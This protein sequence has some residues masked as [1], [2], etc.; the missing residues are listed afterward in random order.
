MPLLRSWP[1]DPCRWVPVRARV[2]VPL[3]LLIVAAGAAL[4]LF[5]A[6]SAGVQPTPEPSDTPPPS[7]GETPAPGEPA[8][9]P[10]TGEEIDALPERPVLAVKIEN[11]PAA[12]PQAGLEAADVVFEQLTEG[13]ITRF[14]ALY[15]SS[16]AEP[17][18]PVRSARFVDADVLPAYDPLLAI[19]GA[20]E[21]VEDALREAGLTVVEEGQAEGFFRSGDRAAPHNL[22]LR[23]QQ[24][25]DAVEGPP[26]PREVVWEYADEPPAGGTSGDSLVVAMSDVSATGWTYDAEAGRYRREQDGAPFTVAGSGS[27]GAA[28]VVVVGV[29]TEAIPGQDSSGQPLLGTRV[30]GAGP[31]IVLRDGRRYEAEWDKPSASGHFSFTGLDGDPLALKPG[32]T[33][34]LLAPWDRLPPPADAPSDAPGATD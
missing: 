30:I 29:E 15:H 34:L 3:V 4:G 21:P 22:F 10:L 1:P 32:P 8:L 23:P 14:L 17:I 16:L 9:A 2:V 20:A 25:L 18:G 27:V 12:R 7:P 5:L 31:A 33:W 28:N 11:S 24:L 19:S 26:P 13:G 6:R